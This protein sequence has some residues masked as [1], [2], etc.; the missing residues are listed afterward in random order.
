MSRPSL[1]FDILLAG[2][3]SLLFLSMTLLLTFFISQHATSRLQ[4]E[5]GMN[6][7]TT[8]HQLSDKLDH[9]MWSR[10]AEVKLLGSLS[11][12]Q[13]TDQKVETRRTLEELQ[14]QIPDFS[15]I[16]RLDANGKVIAS[17]NQIL[18]GTSIKERPVFQE[19]LSQPFIGDV[20]EAVLLAKLLP[21]PSGEP[22]Q[23]VDISTPLYDKGRFSGVLATH[24]S[25][26]WAKAIE[27]SFQSATSSLQKVDVFIVSQD[28]KTIL[29]GP[30]GWSGKTLPTSVTLTSNA[31]ATAFWKEKEFVSGQ[32]TSRG[33]KD[34]DGLGWTVL[35]RQ[36]TSIAFADADAL[37]QTI[38]IAGLI[39]SLITALLGWMLAKLLTRPLLKIT[40]AAQQMQGDPSKSLPNHRGIREIETLTDALQQLIR[41]LLHTEK[42]KLTFERLSQRDSLT[43]LANRNGLAQ[44]IEQ[45]PIGT[46]SIYL[47]LDLDGFKAVNDTYGH[48]LGDLL[49]I[50]VGQRLEQ[51]LPPGGFVAR[52]GG[53]EFI[54]VL[55]HQSVVE[56]QHL[57]E[58][59]IAH[60]SMPYHLEE[61]TVHIGMSIGLAEQIAGE[62][63]EQVMHHADL[64]L[65]RSKQD[66]K[67]CMSVH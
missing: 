62:S 14:R 54:I 32:S 29:L 12:I 49:L 33:Y 47:C 55:T 35:V 42:E 53:D 38:F 15:W 58:Q 48:A 41:R 24:L 60:V 3:I 18:E 37:R 17:T 67:G 66:G 1:R 13:Q 21:N 64:A 43:G 4:S 16:G 25:F 36:P 19:A 10:Y 23:F 31:P 39:A 65:Y 28:R 7:S 27:Q 26:E 52:L 59:W 61:Q 8:A 63:L 50:E 51:L 46:H 6:L 57:G 44:Y 11:T 45:L 20:H 34:Y 22:L 9:Y 5:V 56:A 30:N 40:H 2:L